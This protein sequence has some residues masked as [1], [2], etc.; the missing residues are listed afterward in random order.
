MD[1][2]IIVVE[3][4]CVQAVFSNN[5]DIKVSLCDWDNGE[6]DDDAKK[7]CEELSARCENMT[8]IF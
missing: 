5:P 3:G 6:V 1:E 2:I 7:E 4:G 8:A